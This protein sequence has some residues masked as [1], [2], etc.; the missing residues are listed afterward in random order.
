MQSLKRDRSCYDIVLEYF[1][2]KIT[3]ASQYK[4]VLGLLCFSFKG[5]TPDEILSISQ[6]DS[7]TLN[8]MIALLSHFVCKSDDCVRVLDNRIIERVGSL[9]FNTQESIGSLRASIA[10]SLEG[11][12]LS[13]R[14]LEEQTNN[15]FAAQ[16]YFNL[17][18][19]L[20]RIEVFMILYN[21]KT[22]FDLFKFWKSLELKG[23]DPVYEYNKSLALF[24]MHYSPS[25]RSIFV[26]HVQL[27][28]FFKEIGE[29]EG[30]MTPAFR[31]PHIK[32]K[33]VHV[34]SQMHQHHEGSKDSFFVSF[35]NQFALDQ[36][37]FMTT[38]YQN[39]SLIFRSDESQKYDV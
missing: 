21:E 34:M 20:S 29:S 17:K 16:E 27:G 4:Q 5:L 24:E 37:H 15:Y 28:R 35:S 9:Y 12:E 30:E 22:K 19:V 32:G 8:L 10:Q 38:H 25:N 1:K 3:S 26:I 23:Y 31:H 2:D 36:S 18:Q 13:L 11:G 33:V 6:I 14:I 7:P 39:L